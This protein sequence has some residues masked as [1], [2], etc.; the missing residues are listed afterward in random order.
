MKT[1]RRKKTK[2]R[3]FIPKSLSLHPSFLEL[4]QERSSKLGYGF[5]Q[6]VRYLIAYDLEHG[7]VAPD[8][9]VKLSSKKP[10]LRTKG[11]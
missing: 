11:E 2:G 7:I 8:A 10:G 6:Y 9:M 3:S 1:T 5:S 4:A